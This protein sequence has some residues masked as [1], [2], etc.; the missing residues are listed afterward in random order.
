MCEFMHLRSEPRLGRKQQKLP[1][2]RRVVM[3]VCLIIFVC[4]T[5]VHQLRVAPY[6]R[7]GGFVSPFGG[8][9]ETFQILPPQ[10]I[11]DILKQLSG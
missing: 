8:E 1:Y 3:L 4:G 5:A 6:E 2:E 10:S 9:V 11:E 7:S